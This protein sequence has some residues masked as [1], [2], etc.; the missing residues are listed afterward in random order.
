MK[1]VIWLWLTVS[2]CWL[3]IPVRAQKSITANADSLIVLSRQALTKSPEEQIHIMPTLLK[4]WH[5]QRLPLDTTYIILQIALAYAYVQTG[6]REEAIPLLKK[7]INQYQSKNLS[8]YSEYVLKAYY[9][10]VNCQRGQGDFA[11]ARATAEQGVRVGLQFPKSRWTSHLYG[12]QAYILLQSGDYEKALQ[13]AEQG[14]RYGEQA[15]DAFGIANGLFEKSKALDQLGRIGETRPYLERAI[16]LIKKDPE[17]TY[18]LSM[19]YVALAYVYQA[20]KNLDQSLLYFRRGIALNRQLND[21][22]GLGNNNI[23]LGYF[24]YEQGQYAQA[25]APLQ[26]AVK[27]H[28]T[29]FGKARALDNLG[30]VYWQKKDFN[31][32][33]TAYQ[34]GF[35]FIL[36]SFPDKAITR[37]PDPKTVQLSSHKEYLLTLIQ[38]KADTWL[39]WGKTTGKQAHF[40]HAL[41]TYQLAD[42]MIDFMR[43]EHTGTGSKLYWRQKTRGLYERAIETCYRLGDTEQAYRF[44]E[45]SRAVMLTDKLNELGAHDKLTPAQMVQETGFRQ[46]ITDLQTELSTPESRCQSLYRRSDEA[47]GGTGEF[48]RFCAATRTVQPGVLP[49]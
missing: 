45:K 11:G 39:D 43:W 30:A 16:Q 9:R 4:S 21:S 23:D 47:I 1:T 46:R 40:Q 24:L 35:N 48:R 31:R 44:F 17:R 41:E 12:A 32:A 38:D 14:V 6:H 36:S 22:L 49:V 5:N 26:E 27:C 20:E 33:L 19:Y 2:T 8:G 34:Q 29:P 28:P 18:D 13:S 42:Q 10:L 3:T 7:V 15:R 25:I 37:L